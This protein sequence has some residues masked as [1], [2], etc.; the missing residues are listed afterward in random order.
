MTIVTLIAL[1]VGLYFAPRA[2]ATHDNR[3]NAGYVSYSQLVH[4][5]ANNSHSIATKGGAFIDSKSIESGNV[6]S[7]HQTEVN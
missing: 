7:A 4:K 2:V 3:E 5:L 1:G 6:Q